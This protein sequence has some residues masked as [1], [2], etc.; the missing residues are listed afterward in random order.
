MR[1][2]N[3]KHFEERFERVRS[4]LIEDPAGCKGRWNNAFS[5]NGGRP[6]RLEIGCG[7]GAFIYGT[8]KANPGADF[9]ALEVVPTVILMAMEKVF[10]DP[11]VKN[12]R[13]ILADARSLSDF[14]EED[15]I[16][17]IYLNFSDPWPRKKQHKNRLTHPAFLAQYK[18]IL[19]N[20]H[21]ISQ[22]TD[23]QDL[24]EFSLES[25]A[26]CGF[27]TE[28]PEGTPGDNVM[29]EYERR[30]TELGQPIFRVNAINR[31]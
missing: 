15:E 14:F 16:D 1:P 20:G 13:F 21:M 2:R 25:Y 28:I 23:N 10:E 19:K 17:R 7:K 22:K 31:K 24:F 18:K 5:G 30:F 4:L 6:V 12:V 8:A 26:A 27:D 11:E 29:T 3:K 9:V